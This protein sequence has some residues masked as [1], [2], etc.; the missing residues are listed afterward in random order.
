MDVIDEYQSDFQ[1]EDDDKD[2]LMVDCNASAEVTDGVLGVEELSR[3]EG[4]SCFGTVSIL[5]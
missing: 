1:D 2:I 5:H 4:E 3:S